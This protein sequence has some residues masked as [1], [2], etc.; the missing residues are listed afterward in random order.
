MKTH[1]AA[2]FLM[3]TAGWPLFCVFFYVQ[4]AKVRTDYFVYTGAFMAAAVA[5]G[6]IVLAAVICCQRLRRLL[7]WDVVIMYT[8]VYA[9]LAFGSVLVLGSL[10]A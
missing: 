9:V 7:T 3:L 4:L 1:I 5:L 8:C 10:G 6:P 2:L